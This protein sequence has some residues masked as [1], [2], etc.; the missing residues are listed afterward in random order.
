MSAVGW[1]LPLCLARCGDAV[2]ARLYRGHPRERGRLGGARERG[3]GAGRARREETPTHA[4]KKGRSGAGCPPSPPATPS[5]PR[6]RQLTCAGGCA[7]QKGGATRRSARDGRATRARTAAAFQIARPGAA[8]DATPGV[9]SISPDAWS[10]GVGRWT[11][12]W[13]WGAPVGVQREEKNALAFVGG[14]GGRP[15]PFPRGRRSDPAPLS[16]PPP[17]TM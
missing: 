8:V 14:R 1:A 9:G 2:G 3:G 13:G 4:E 17:P 10:A 16:T 6:W 15:P 11:R 12:I 5:P 7:P